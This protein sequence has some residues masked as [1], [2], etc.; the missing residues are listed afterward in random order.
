MRKPICYFLQNKHSENVWK[1][2]T[3][4]KSGKIQKL[5]EPRRKYSSVSTG[6]QLI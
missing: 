5:S 2:V 6:V 1:E 3:N 4:K